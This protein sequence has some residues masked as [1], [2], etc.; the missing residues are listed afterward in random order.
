M[1]RILLLAVVALI[2]V[3]GVAAAAEPP[4]GASSCTGCHA[5]RGGVDS[6]VPN[7]TGRS[8]AALAAEMAAFRNGAR[9][10]TVMGR[11]AR[12]FSDAEIQAI[13]DWYAAQK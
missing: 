10:G 5:L 8:A 7:L 4:P 11:I 13:A 3:P 2:A 6:A 9:P 1:R 12:G